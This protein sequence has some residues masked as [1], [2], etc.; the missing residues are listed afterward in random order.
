MTSSL[1]IW[2]LFVSFPSLLAPLEL[3]YGAEQKWQEQAAGPLLTVEEKPV[4]CHHLAG[5]G[6]GLVMRP[7]VVLSRFPSIPSSLSVFIFKNC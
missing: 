1:P 7:F 4:A 6:C 5:A 3:A 2:T